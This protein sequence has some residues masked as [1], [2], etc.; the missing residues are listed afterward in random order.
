MSRRVSCFCCLTVFERMLQRTPVDV[1]ALIPREN[2]KSLLLKELMETQDSVTHPMWREYK[3]RGTRAGNYPFSEAL[4][5]NI[6]IE[7]L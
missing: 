3:K 1:R 4:T 5:I 6:A 7:M 2:G